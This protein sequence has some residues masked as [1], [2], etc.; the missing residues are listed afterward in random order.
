MNDSYYLTIETNNNNNNSYR[1]D[2]EYRI[3]ICPCSS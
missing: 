3:T 2:V 1:L